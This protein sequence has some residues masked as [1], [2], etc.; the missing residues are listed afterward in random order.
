MSLPSFSSYHND[1]LDYADD[2]DDDDDEEDP[3]SPLLEDLYCPSSI[4]NAA[5]SGNLRA[6]KDLLS[7]NPSLLHSMDERRWT[8]LHHA[9]W[10]GNQ[11]MI[12]FLLRAGASVN[13]VETKPVDTPLS[14]A[15]TC[16]NEKA[17]LLLLAHHAVPDL[18]ITSVLHGAI[19]HSNHSLLRALIHAGADVNRR[20]STGW[21]TA[22][23]Y[24][25]YRHDRTSVVELLLHNANPNIQRQGCSVLS[26][27]L[28]RADVHMTSLLLDGGADPNQPAFS[29]IS[30]LIYKNS[31]AT[32][33][34]REIISML[35]LHG[36]HLNEGGSDV[37]ASQ[38]DSLMCWVE[39][40][41]EELVTLLI[42]H[43]ADCNKISAKA[44]AKI[45]AMY[46]L[47][48]GWKE[49]DLARV[50]K[51]KLLMKIP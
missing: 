18:S 41:A 1:S 35:I 5:S 13:G 47:E 2:D 17:A 4:W 48:E 28:T 29:V 32:G 49:L 34:W 21:A 19:T 37:H 3:R 24:A 46:Q 6:V 51:R 12:D 23:F 9:A 30:R 38:F 40:S 39:P 14:V 33:T 7:T 45:A 11:E 20:V 8:P 50:T 22:I 44:R 25:V 31:F 10:S 36:A 16:N 43:G 26:V 27:A 42:S 15:V